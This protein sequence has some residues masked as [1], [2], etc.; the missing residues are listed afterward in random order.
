MYCYSSLSGFMGVR[1]ELETYMDIRK[2]LARSLKLA[3]RAKGLVQEDFSDVSGRTY[4]SEMERGVKSPTLE[5]ID[6][7]ARVMKLHPLTVIALA[8]AQNLQA[9]DIESLLNRVRGET[10]ALL[11]HVDELQPG[12]ARR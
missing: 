12:K 1:S 10:E 11:R 4:L 3:R 8:Y 9:R 7:L 2:G 5:K 6:A